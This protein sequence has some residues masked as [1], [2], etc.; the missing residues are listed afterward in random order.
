MS[1][2]DLMTNINKDLKKTREIV[3]KTDKTIELGLIDEITTAEQKDK[4]VETIEKV[5]EGIDAITGIKKVID[6]TFDNPTIEVEVVVQE[7]I[8]RIFDVKTSQLS[9]EMYK[10]AI[11][12]RNK[13]YEEIREKVANEQF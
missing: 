5:Q 10:K 6:Q 7:A 8:E 4:V 13:I 12:L 2:R 11:S 1:V 3:L 9:Y